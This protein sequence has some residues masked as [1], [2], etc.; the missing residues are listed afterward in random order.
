MKIKILPLVILTTALSLLTAPASASLILGT[1]TQ[2][3]IGGD[4]TDP[5]NDGL[6]DSNV[7]YNATFRSSVEQG[8]GGGEYA[9]NVFDNILSGGNGKWCCN[10]GTVWVEADFGSDQY[11][12]DT[13]T[14]SSANDVASRDSDQWSIL[15]S[16]DGVNYTTIFSYDVAGLS[17]WGADRFEVVEFS[18]SDDYNVNTAYSI[19]RYQSTSVVSGS[20]HQLGE[21]EFFGTKIPEP[22][23]IA[24]FALGMIGLASR[25]LKKKS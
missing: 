2:A 17:I 14:L 12:L 4:L 23:T 3:L 25:R 18:N 24:I 15:G 20:A 6:A 5:E 21:I 7:N 11:I 1:G 8:F 22:S 10:G 13:F 16:N 9:F 19:F